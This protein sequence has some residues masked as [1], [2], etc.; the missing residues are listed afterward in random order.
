MSRSNPQDT[1]VNP[2]TRWFEWNGETGVVR[3]Y[4]KAAQ[5]TV[6]VGDDF[7]FL[8]LDQLGCVKGWHEPSKSSIYSQG[9]HVG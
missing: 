3:Y 7:T 6:D 4:D 5:R 2:S 9:R 1:A 8:L